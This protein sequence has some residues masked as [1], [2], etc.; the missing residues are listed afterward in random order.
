MKVRQGIRL[1]AMLM[2]VAF[3]GMLVACQTSGCASAVKDANVTFAKAMAEQ[4]T[5]ALALA[6]KV[7]TPTT[8]GPPLTEQQARYC[9]ALQASLVSQ[10]QAA[11]KI[12]SEKQQE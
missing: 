5:A 9:A 2:V 3:T 12:A 4:S 11:G 10:Q 1:A 8:E 7:C 6:T